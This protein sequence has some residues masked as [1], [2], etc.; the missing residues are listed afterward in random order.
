ME[1]TVVA[2]SAAAAAA[3]EAALA[4]SAAAATAAK[5]AAAAAATANEAAAATKEAAS[6]SSAAALNAKEAAVVASATALIAKEAADVAASAWEAAA[7]AAASVA[8]AMQASKKRK[9]H[10]IDNRQEPPESANVDDGENLDFISRL[11]DDVLGSV[12]SLLPTKEGARTQA[13]SRRWR[14]LW[15]SAP[16]NLVADEEFQSKGLSTVPLIQKILSEHPGPARRFAYIG[17]SRRDCHDN[18]GDWLSSQALNNLH[19]LE[20]TYYHTYCDKKN[21]VYLLPSSVYRFADTLRVA[22][23]FGCHFPDL[24]VQLSLKFPHL[25]QLTLERVTSS[26]DALLSILS[27]CSS[28]ESLMLINN[29]GISHLR[30]SF[31]TL[32]SLGLSADR[33]IGKGAVNLHELV[34]E[35][36]PCLER[37]LPLVPEKAPATIRIISAPKL[38]ILGVLSGDIAEL[39]FGT[40]VFQKMIAVGLPTKIHTVR[41]LVLDS[42]GLN[43]DKV[44]NFL[45]CFPCVERLYFSFQSMDFV[46]EHDPLDRI[47]CLELHLKEM[48]LKNYDGTKPAC[49]DFTKF[50]ILNA[51]VLKEMKITLAYHRQHRWFANQRRL[52]QIENRASRDARIELTCGSKDYFTHVKHIHDLS[53]ADLFDE[54]SSGCSKCRS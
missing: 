37:L 32:K 31:Q 24:I 49:I 16:L 29:F 48:V 41:V 54:P 9:F 25:K 43:L 51:K 17:G 38:E 26:E 5:D 4:A 3:K 33:W 2:A 36:A 13:I 46:Q 39:Q 18:I 40:T 23:L 15:R 52:L 34:I 11:P 35:D 44:V 50:F 47:E 20:L 30:V 12:V 45:K 14:P 42:Y 8:L 53:M 7:A 19:E 6:A 22:S 28:L 1:A 27:G 10:L 21:H